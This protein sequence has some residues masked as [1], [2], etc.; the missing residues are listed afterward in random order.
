MTQDFCTVMLVKSEFLHRIS[1]LYLLYAPHDM[2]Y[3]QLYI[4]LM[5]HAPCP[6]VL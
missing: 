1:L 2:T 3:F 5:T 4:L 6:V